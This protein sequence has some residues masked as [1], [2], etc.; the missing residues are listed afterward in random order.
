MVIQTSLLQEF[1]EEFLF[2]WY[3]IAIQEMAT[4]KKCKQGC[5]MAVQYV[6]V[7]VQRH[8][9]EPS[10]KVTATRCRW[11]PWWWG[12]EWGTESTIRST[13][14]APQLIF[15]SAVQIHKAQTKYCSLR[16]TGRLIVLL[17][18]EVFIIW[19]ESVHSLWRSCSSPRVYECHQTSHTDHNSQ[20]TTSSIF[21]FQWTTSRLTTLCVYSLFWPGC[22]VPQYL[23]DLRR[24]QMTFIWLH[25]PKY[26]RRIMQM[27]KFSLATGVTGP[28]CSMWP[29]T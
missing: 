2:A 11:Q 19:M 17:L 26:W 8:Y 20:V 10:F 13:Y 16:S 7:Q 28:V 6:N 1:Q 21:I 12:S 25:K 24:L 15:S 18:N 9:E 22:S 3:F 5:Y 29:W 4:G 14:A 23:E 27:G